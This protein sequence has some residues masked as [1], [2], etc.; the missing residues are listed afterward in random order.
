LLCAARFCGLRAR[1]RKQAHFEED[2]FNISIEETFAQDSLIRQ[3]LKTSLLRS[4]TQRTGEQTA[5]ACDTHR[6]VNFDGAVLL[7][8]NRSAE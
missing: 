7:H 2:T 4:K 3:L 5:Q 1:E 6:G 8:R